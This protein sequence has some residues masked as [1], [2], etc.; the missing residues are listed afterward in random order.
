MPDYRLSLLFRIQSL[1]ELDRSKVLT[2]EKVTSPFENKSTVFIFQWTRNIWVQHIIG[3]LH[4][5][6]KISWEVLNILSLGSFLYTNW[7]TKSFDG[8]EKKSVCYKAL[9]PYFFALIQIFILTSQVEAINMF[10]P[11]AEV[12][13]ARDHMFHVTKSLLQPTRIHDR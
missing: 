6:H 11:P 5:F 2:E 9:F 10:N 3:Y 7:A 12:I 13:A 8:L 1:T 4:S